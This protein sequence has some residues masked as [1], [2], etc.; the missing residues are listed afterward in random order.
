MDRR[1]VGF[2]GIMKFSSKY[3]NINRPRVGLY[4]LLAYPTISYILS[5]YSVCWG[6]N[7]V[8]FGYAESFSCVE[9][10]K[11]YY[12]LII[13]L[14][15]IIVGYFIFKNLLR[16]KKSSSKEKVY[17]L[18]ERVMLLALQ[19]IILLYF[20]ISLYFFQNSDAGFT[21]H[22]APRTLSTKSS[23][24]LVMMA[25]IISIIISNY[26]GINILSK[27]NIMCIVVI[28]SW[29]EGSRTA[30]IPL[31]VYTIYSMYNKKL[32]NVLTCFVLII[33]VYNLSISGRVAFDKGM[34]SFIDTLLNVAESSVL[35][36]FEYSYIFQFSYL[37][38]MYT[39]D[40]ADPVFSVSDLLFSIIPI[41]SS[42]H[43]IDADPDQWRIDIYRPF[44][45]MAEIFTVGYFY[46]V[47]YNLIIG[48]IAGIIDKD[49]NKI[50]KTIAMGIIIFAF[51][52]SFQYGMRT[53]QWFIYGGVIVIVFYKATHMLI[54]RRGR[55]MLGNS[56]DI[57]VP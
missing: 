4:A 29:I 55:G 22:L 18:E 21:P 32:L 24:V 8:A 45:G 10:L 41:P 6:V 37:H 46:Y 31:I 9:V 49:D 50:F 52:S 51:V 57:Y 16:A 7:D 38:F 35:L 20:I 13:Q 26:K 1:D 11:N 40:Y 56:S 43:F 28:F 42:M 12:I 39:I 17:R 2:A 48:G 3:H 14:I 33:F 27:F 25:T 5:I 53:V 34:W 44:G 36:N 19:Y 54:Y 47:M 30:L 23:Q 15:S